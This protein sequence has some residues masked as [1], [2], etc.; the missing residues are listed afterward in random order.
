MR[1]NKNGLSSIS[2]LYTSLQKNHCI[3]MAQE[4][5]LC[6]KIFWVKIPT[7]P[8]NVASSWAPDPLFLSKNPQKSA[9]N[10]LK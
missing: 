1:T 5:G 7:I 8:N 4:I 9:K 6:R 3:L 10:P 2:F